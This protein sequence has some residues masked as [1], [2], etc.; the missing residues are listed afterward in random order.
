MAEAGE[1]AADSLPIL[2]AKYSYCYSVYERC[3][4][5]VLFTVIYINNPRLTPIE[6]LFHLNAKTS[7]DA[8]NIVS[9][10]PLSN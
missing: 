7:G 4:F 9:N 10:S 6:K 2:Q 8:H 5:R 3:G 1:S